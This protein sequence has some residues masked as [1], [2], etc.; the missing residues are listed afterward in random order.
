MPRLKVLCSGGCGQ[1]THSADR[2]CDT[3]RRGDVPPV[4]RETS[5]VSF[6]HYGQG[7]KNMLRRHIVA[8]R[9]LGRAGYRI[10]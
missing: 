8:A 6:A 3:C 7:S 5:I 4:M 9:E 1:P 10:G 2:M